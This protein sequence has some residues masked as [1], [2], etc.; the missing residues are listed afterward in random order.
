MPKWTKELRPTLALALPIM[1]G[2]VSQMLMGILDS[3]MVG[4]AAADDP[5]ELAGHGACGVR[6][7]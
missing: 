4:R 3:V 7:L 2:Q 5:H 1:V 6:H